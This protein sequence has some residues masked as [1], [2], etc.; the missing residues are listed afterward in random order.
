MI[1]DQHL[2]RE[3][4]TSGKNASE[5]S[6]SMTGFAYRIFSSNIYQHKI[7]AIVR[8]LSCNAYDSHLEAGKV[9]LPFHVG[10]PGYADP[11]FYV[12]DFGTGL[13]DNGVRNVFC[14]YFG[15]TKT[16]S[17]EVT[18]AYGLGSKT[19]FAY[20]DSFS[21]RARKD[22]IERNYLAFIGENS[23]PQIKI[24]N[25]KETD[26]CNGVRVSLS[27]SE[28]DVEKFKNEA[29]F[30][31]SFMPTKPIVH[32]S[33]DFKF[34]VEDYKEDLKENGLVV[35]KRRLVNSILYNKIPH[36]ILMANVC[37][38]VH[39]SKRTFLDALYYE[40]SNQ[41]IIEVPN[42]TFMPAPSRENFSLE[43]G[44]QEK[45]DEIFEKAGEKIFNKIQQEINDQP[46]IFDA[47]KIFFNYF[48][49]YNMVNTG[50]TYHGKDVFRK[51]IGLRSIKLSTIYEKS[52]TF[53]RISDIFIHSLV[54]TKA[55]FFYKDAKASNT[56]FRQKVK[57]WRKEN[58]YP[59][60]Y[61]VT[62][63]ISKLRASRISRLLDATL[64]PYSE[65][66]IKNP[67]KILKE[68]SHVKSEKTKKRFMLR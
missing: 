18:G 13:D 67:E 38:P 21:I 31:L 34:S 37:Y 52:K 40:Y 1:I 63:M 25:T 64:I 9:D 35:I 15:S 23:I 65:I 3:V 36:M 17:N 19:P 48:S 6:A 54:K 11:V 24:L 42:G 50:L 62:D 55:Y 53:S 51:T 60:V 68:E 49:P 66:K 4:V 45:I 5:F 2:T 39:L 30:I 56:V 20:S 28:M 12:E 41:I 16:G 47:V 14:T 29:E 58:G 61:I 22:G 26:E 27:V 8:E 44:D 7:A 43:N 10:L 57:K 46:K 32:G 59:V 33:S